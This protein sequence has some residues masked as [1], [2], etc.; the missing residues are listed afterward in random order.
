MT[1]STF[2]PD[3]LAGKRILVTGGGTGLGKEMA[4]TFVGHG[5]SGAH[6][7][8]P[9]RRAA[10]SGRELRSAAQHGG[11]IAISRVRRARSRADRSHGRAH[12]AGGP[13]TGLVNTAA[14]NFISPS[15]EIS[16]RGR[17]RAQHGDG[18]RVFGN[19]RLR[20]ALDPRRPA[21]Q[22]VSM[23]VTW[24]WTGSAYVLPST[25]AKTAVH[26]MTM[27]LAVEWGKH[28]IRVNAVAP[29]P[30]PDRKR[31][32]KLAP[33]QR[34]N[35]GAAR[36]TRCRW[37]A[38]AACPSSPTCSPSC[39]PTAAS[40]SPAR[41]SPS[42]AATTWPRPAPRGF[43][44]AHARGLG[45]G[46]GAGAGP[47]REKGAAQHRLM[48]AEAAEVQDLRRHRG[49]SAGAAG[50]RLRWPG[51]V[52]RRT[53]NAGEPDRRPLPR[54][55]PVRGDHVATLLGNRPEAL[56]AGMGRLAQRAYLTPLATTL[57]PHELRYLVEDSDARA[58]LV[59]A[60]QAEV[61][62]ALPALVPTRPRWLVAERRHR[63]FR[64]RGAD[65]AERLR[66][67]ARRRTAGALMMYTSGTTGAPQGVIRPLLPAGWRARRLCGRPSSRSS[68]S[69][70]P[71][72]AT[73]RP[74]C[75]T[76]RR[77][78]GTALAVT[79]GGGTVIVMDRFDA[80]AAPALLEREAIT[81]SQ[82]VPAM[83]QRLLALPTAARGLLRARCAP[84]RHP[85]CRAL[86][87]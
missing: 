4:R 81:H 22:R 43:G 32:E 35:V 44:Q 39:R 54:A 84:L 51:A 66:P 21:R 70:A 57:T 50:H 78:C 9:R 53:G 52:V 60:A 48:A 61:A 64:A 13:P 68:A 10:G 67:A 38:S 65:A 72:C 3:V 31:G 5:A 36:P 27:S 7:R 80:E 14:A 25:M 63:R 19:A 75:C 18:R 62:A 74:R 23:L 55:G 56:A 2:R 26:A 59:D 69:A 17:R 76:T 82:W 47:R 40:T 6:L 11:S 87:A 85:R 77:R 79:A 29:G 34:A 86:P 37:A 45:R 33:F 58:V 46:E 28:N 15:T 41:T 16:P 42:T 1:P 73:S 83:F 8:P 24:V 49:G 30:F 20:Q 12:L 71:T